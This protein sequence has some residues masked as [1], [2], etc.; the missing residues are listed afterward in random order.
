MSPTIRNVPQAAPD[1]RRPQ[2]TPGADALR[3]IWARASERQPGSV[4]AGYP[5]NPLGSGAPC[6][7][8]YRRVNEREN[9]WGQRC[10]CGR[11]V[12]RKLQSTEPKP[13]STE[14][15][16]DPGG[17]R[18]STTVE[19]VL[20][21]PRDFDPAPPLP[22]LKVLIVGAYFPRYRQHML[23]ELDRSQSFDC[24]LV[25]GSCS[26]PTIAVIARP[27]RSADTIGRGHL[28]DLFWQDGYARYIW[29]NRYK[30]D[31]FV[32]HGDFH[33]LSTW[34]A[35]IALIIARRKSYLWTQGWGKNRSRGWIVEWLKW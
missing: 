18:S 4:G 14:P 1:L 23:A 7:M 3:P 15:K 25:S 5:G 33:F 17:R 21:D 11:V 6:D 32:I 10:R 28:P 8:D 13:D 19:G 31:R 29:L 27:T 34:V 9:P 2:R 20:V 12:T 26:D 24:H 22:V 30:Y 35:L 16:P